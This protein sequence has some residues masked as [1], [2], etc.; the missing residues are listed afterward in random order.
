MKSVKKMK[1]VVI[2][3]SILSAD[4]TRLADE[5]KRLSDAGCDTIHV[6]VMD[7][8]F[9]PNITFG[10]AVLTHVNR[11]S[12]LPLDVHLM[13]ADPG[14]YIEA[15][16]QERVASICV[17]AEACGHLDRTLR[18]IREAGKSPAVALNPATPLSSIEWVLHLVDLVIVMTV[19]PGFGGQKFIE[20]MLPK[21]QSLRK[22]IDRR[23][24][25]V[26]LGIDGGVTDR[27]VKRLVDAGAD[28]FVMGNYLFTATE[29]IAKAVTKVR[30]LC[31]A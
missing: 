15:F 21:V 25:A 8:I 12:T 16:A 20:E 23:K 30:R 29:G 26:T 14:R 19:N 27:N 4:F 13:I 6:D 24:L 3:P 2:S 28:Y 18:Q 17:H 1:R 10:Q 7:G 22:E 9:V 31:G 11:A 5:M